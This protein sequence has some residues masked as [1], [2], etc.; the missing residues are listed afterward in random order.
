MKRPQQPTPHGQD[1]RSSKLRYDE[2]LYSSYEK[3]FEDI[4]KHLIELSK[5]KAQEQKV[6]DNLKMA[7]QS[8]RLP[9][10]RPSPDCKKHDLD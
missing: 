3:I 5:K 1:M 7:P 9:P 4:H 2:S 10:I 8:R 6:S